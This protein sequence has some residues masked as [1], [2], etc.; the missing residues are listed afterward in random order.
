MREAAEGTRREADEARVVEK[1]LRTEQ[2]ELTARIRTLESERVGVDATLATVVAERDTVML[3]RDRLRTERDRVDATLATV[4]AE[5]DT[6]MQER[7]RLRAERDR[8]RAERDRVDATLATIV[9][10]RD[11]LVG[12]FRQ[13]Q[14]RHSS[15]TVRRISRLFRSARVRAW[16]LVHLPGVPGL[17]TNP[18]FDRE[19]YLTRYPDVRSGRLPAYRHYQR[20]GV[21]EGR[22]PNALFDSD[23]YLERNPDV[24]ASGMNPLDH[25][26]LF[27]AAEGRD[28]GLGFHTDWYLRQNPDVAAAGINPLQHFLRYG[29]VEGRTPTPAT[30]SNGQVVGEPGSRPTHRLAEGTEAGGT[31]AHAEPTAPKHRVTATSGNRAL[32]A[33]RRELPAGARVVIADE[34]EGGQAPPDWHAALLSRDRGGAYLGFP[35]PSGRSAIIQ[36]EAARMDRAEYLLLPRSNFW[37][38]NKYRELTSH[39]ERLYRLEL[40]DKEVAIWAL[41]EPGPWRLVNDLLSDLRACLGRE[42]IILDWDS[43]AD[44]ARLLPFCSVFSP[45]AE[46]VGLPYLDGTADVVVIGSRHLRNQGEAERVATTAVVAV[47]VSGARPA[48]SILWRADDHSPRSEAISIVVASDGNPAI[49]TAQMR[50]LAQTLPPSA[51]GEIVAVGPQ[52]HPPLMSSDGDLDTGMTVTNITG[53]PDPRSQFELGVEAAST[54]LVVLLDGGTWPIAGWLTA[55]RRAFQATAGTTSVCGTVVEPDARLI[56]AGGEFDSS[57]RPV[58]IGEGTYDIDAPRYNHTRPVDFGAVGFML[59]SRELF[60]RAKVLPAPEDDPV[61]DIAFSRRLHDAGSEIR[62]EPEA[63]AVR[64]WSTA[65][66]QSA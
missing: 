5:R 41:N 11:T 46:E 26:L 27:G 61:L 64:A 52:D 58:R 49:R 29:V 38:L 54:E 59:T 63:I 30:V 28:P 62:Y 51:R 42:P 12:Q 7:D 31:S 2:T 8:L 35:P 20:H 6:V 44:M 60:L 15:S 3:E 66:G 33:A 23:W 65:A 43:E 57:G 19:W 21:A 14:N 17:V 48:A 34:G 18:L 22:D 53:P 32:R 40:R 10:E 45:P 55:M 13:I 9:A 37:W 50:W 24:R 56:M 25:Y 4:V 36:L 47:D 39:L 1:A 16:R